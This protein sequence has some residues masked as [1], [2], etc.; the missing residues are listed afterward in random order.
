[1]RAD[2]SCTAQ[3]RASAA[4]PK[5]L[6]VQCSN[7]HRSLQSCCMRDDSIF[8]QLRSCCRRISLGRRADSRH[9]S[10]P[11]SKRCML[12]QAAV[13]SM[14]CCTPAVGLLGLLPADPEATPPDIIIT[15]CD[16]IHDLEMH[17]AGL[18]R[19][20]FLDNTE[21][22]RF[23]GRFR[24]TSREGQEKVAGRVHATSPPPGQQSLECS[25]GPR[26][27]AIGEHMLLTVPQ[28]KL[29]IHCWHVDDGQWQASGT[30]CSSSFA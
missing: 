19:L 4:L 24:L 30:A 12:P 18:A 1:M 29:L 2:V 8:L 15:I 6:A 10:T 7:R 11:H 13:A 26:E 21:H 17:C 25:D 22:E 14:R 28:N 16:C 5:D 23:H 27:A 3:Q 9:P 20:A